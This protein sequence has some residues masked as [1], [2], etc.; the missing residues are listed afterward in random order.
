M[1]RFLPVLIALLFQAQPLCAAT[2][3][4]IDE[5]LA[6]A[7][8]SH[9]RIAE[10]KERLTGAE[11]RTGLALA[12]YYPQIGIASDWSRGR[13]FL[14]ALER[15]K[16]TQVAVN[17]LYLQQTI[18]DFGRT[19]GAVDAAIGNRDA[20]D[21]ALTLTRQDLALRVKSAF[22]SLLAAEKQVAATEET[23]KAREDVHRQ[24]LE[25]FNQGVRAK[26]DVARAEA[27]LYAA[28][29][30][31]IRAGNGRDMARVEL[32]N[33]MGI[34]SLGPLS[35][36]AA[37]PLPA[38]LPDL[39]QANRTALVG[40][41]ELQQLSALETAADAHLRV[42]KGSYLPILSGTASVGYAD[43]DFPPTGNVW[44]VGLNLTVP[45]FSGFS[46]REQVREARADIGA[47]S[48]RQQDLRLQ[49]AKEVESAWLGVREASARIAST[50]KGA[51]A[52]EE[53]RA[54]AEG[55]Y[56]EGVGSIIEVTDAQ[57]LAL[58]AQSARIQAQYD[59]YTEL[60]RLDRT[61]GR[62]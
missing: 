15:A 51:A 60:A 9:P 37:A 43:R 33:A 54:L 10:A 44:A 32:A 36:V 12:H 48:A 46:S 20:A 45:L 6:T 40:R 8:K 14:T 49:I 50:E 7:L 42:A 23:V 13:T 29:T 24:A 21:Q 25:F 59:Y 31:L 61:L 17:A 52:A 56:Q 22:Y 47:L 26:V 41:A 5:A 55:R 35:P 1:K 27:N 57:S 58:E 2:S 18:Y 19:A 16:T 4:T 38:T 28:R 62:P 39:S 53:N 11:A 30:A 3:L 34:A